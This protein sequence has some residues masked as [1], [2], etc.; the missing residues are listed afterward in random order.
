MRRVAVIIGSAGSETHS[1]ILALPMSDRGAVALALARFGADVSA[2]ASDSDA[3][4]FARAAGVETVA[5]ISELEMDSFD[6]ALIGRG[7]CGAS[8][9]A[10][11]ARLAEESGAALVYDAIDVNWESDRL[12]VTRDLGRGAR[13]LLNVRGRTI[14]VVAESVVRGPYVSRYRINAEKAAGGETPA[15]EAPSSV[16]W[17][18]ATPRVRLGDHASRVAGRAMERMNALY[19]VGEIGEN[20]ASLV[21]GSAEECAR[22]LLRYL[23]HHGFVEH[24]VDEEERGAPERTATLQSAERKSQPAAV[25]TVSIPIRVRRRP[26]YLN[27]PLLPTRGP[28]EIGVDT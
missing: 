16:G 15:R 8:G 1:G 19:G 13:D 27:D 3:R 7:G 21:R 10:L 6:V 12:V 18:L 25:G 14:L 23:S 22:H 20:S 5:E 17:E 9:D 26:R 11:P 2:Y 24:G 4:Y 28:L